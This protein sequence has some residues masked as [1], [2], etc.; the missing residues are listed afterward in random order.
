MVNMTS[1]QTTLYKLRPP[2]ARLGPGNVCM[3]ASS[4][5]D[6]GRSISG[7][8][9]LVGSLVGLVGLGGA[10]GMLGLLVQLQE[11]PSLED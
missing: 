7:V 9:Y 4:L 8:A 6:V 2:S 10:I 5:V 11:V 1:A 3:H